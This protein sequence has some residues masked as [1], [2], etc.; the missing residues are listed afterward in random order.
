VIVLTEVLIVVVTLAYIAAVFAVLYFVGEKTFWG[1]SYLRQGY[2][3]LLSRR[4]DA[5]LFAAVVLDFAIPLV[6]LCVRDKFILLHINAL[7]KW[8]LFIFFVVMLLCSWLL[9][10]VCTF[11]NDDGLLLS[12]PFQ[13]PRFVPWSEIESIQKKNTSAQLY[14]VVD[15]SKH[16]IGW[17]PLT[18]K[19]QPFLDL[20]QEHGVSVYISKG[21]KMVLNTSSK[22]LKSDLGDWNT[23][24]AMSAY[25]NNDLIAI[26][27]F[28]DFIVA[29]FMDRQ[30]NIDNVIAIN[31]DGTTRWNISDIIKR[32][33]DISYSALSQENANT[34]SVMAVAGRQYDCIIYEIDV[35]A[36][37]I[38]RQYSREDV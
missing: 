36:K 5:Y 16:R 35:Y 12:K 2:R 9:G 17:F 22:K 11:Y 7:T 37:K 24:I 32:P 27:T 18:K 19:T 10:K 29:L 3:I 30:L 34:I 28:P 13:R 6:V 26:A 8:G 25:S 1:K 14:N 21:D 4:L 38:I 15:R 33:K 23:A 31:R 20:A